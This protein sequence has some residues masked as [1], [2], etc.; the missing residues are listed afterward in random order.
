MKWFNVAG[1]AL[2]IIG[3]LLLW[4][5]GLRAEISRSGADYLT[6]EQENEA[7]KALARRYDHLG[8]LGLIVLIL[9]FALQ[10]IGSWPRSGGG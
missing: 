4:R 9:G 3:A 8:R 1:L 5:Y 6:A 7:E 2:D 10:L